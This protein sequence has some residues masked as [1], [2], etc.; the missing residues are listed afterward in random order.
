MDI[1]S[2][3]VSLLPRRR[4]LASYQSTEIRMT[5]IFA[6]LADTTKAA[7]QPTKRAT[8]SPTSSGP[9][10]PA[11]SPRTPRAKSPSSSAKPSG[12]PA[13]PKTRTHPCGTSTKKL[14]CWENARRRRTSS[15]GAITTRTGRATWWSRRTRRRKTRARWRCTSLAQS[16]RRLVN[17]TQLLLLELDLIR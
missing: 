10:Y 11:N 12:A 6:F 1:G 14:I 3:A 4:Q 17:A 2:S 5:N 15:M 9:T 7:S 16:I 13:I 8:P